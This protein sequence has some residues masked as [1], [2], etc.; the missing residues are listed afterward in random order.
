MRSYLKIFKN[1]NENNFK[2]KK[3]KLQYKKIN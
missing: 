2:N 1:K 3:K